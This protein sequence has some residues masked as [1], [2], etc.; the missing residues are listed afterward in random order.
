MIKQIYTNTSIAQVSSFCVD[1]KIISLK[2]HCSFCF[3]CDQI[4]AS[5]SANDIAG[6]HAIVRSICEIQFKC[7]SK[8]SYSN[9]TYR[10][11]LCEC[12]LKYNYSEPDPMPGTDTSQ[13]FTDKCIAKYPCKWGNE[14][15]KG[16]AGCPT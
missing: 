4:M 16:N 2:N 6:C 15:Q 13:S 9:D 3:V 1:P 12:V 14:T 11:V 8:S 7:G 10:P 5:A